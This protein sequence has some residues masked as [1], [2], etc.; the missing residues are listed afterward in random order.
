MNPCR[1]P[2]LGFSGTSSLLASHSGKKLKYVYQQMHAK[3]MSMKTTTKIGRAVNVIHENVEKLKFGKES[4]L[5][6]P[7]LPCN[8]NL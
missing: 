7:T 8:F 5:L 4:L 2:V 3:S 1:P 6:E